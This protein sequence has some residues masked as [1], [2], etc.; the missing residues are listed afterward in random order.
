MKKLEDQLQ[1]LKSELK[2]TKKMIN[3]GNPVGKSL[4]KEKVVFSDNASKEIL[5]N[6]SKEVKSLRNDFDSFRKSHLLSAAIRNAEFN[7][8]K[9]A[10]IQTRSFGENIDSTYLVRCMLCYFQRGSVAIVSKG[11]LQGTSYSSEQEKNKQVRAFYDRLAV[12]IHEL[13]GVKPVMK[14]GND[15]R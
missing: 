11:S 9:F 6:M 8:F 12:Q 13:I 1:S 14:Y 10:Y 15:G 2:K 5:R 3:N 7:S 4:Q